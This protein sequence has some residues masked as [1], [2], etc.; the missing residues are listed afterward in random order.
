VID[1]KAMGRLWEP[2]GEDQERTDERGPN[3]GLNT[4]PE[5]PARGRGSGGERNRANGAVITRSSV[6]VLMTFAMRQKN[7]G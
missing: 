4:I 5:R 7:P 1:G 3:G 2:S 6:T